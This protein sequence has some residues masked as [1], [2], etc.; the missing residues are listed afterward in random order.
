[1]PTSFHR[2]VF[3]PWPILEGRDRDAL[4][5]FISKIKP[6]VKIGNNL[7]KLKLL[8]ILWLNLNSSHNLNL[9]EINHEP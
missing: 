9:P 4:L 7:L 3:L 8:L 6:L 1:L 2:L 5:F